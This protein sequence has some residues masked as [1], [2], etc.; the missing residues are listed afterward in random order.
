MRIAAARAMDW[1]VVQQIMCH[2]EMSERAQIPWHSEPSMRIRG[3]ITGAPEHA[4]ALGGS[5]THLDG[6]DVAFVGSTLG[7]LCR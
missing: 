4:C 1:R 6:L 2:V 7:G 3:A 5:E